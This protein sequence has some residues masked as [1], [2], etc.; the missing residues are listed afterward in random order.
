MEIDLCSIFDSLDMT[1]THTFS[2]NNPEGSTID[3]LAFINCE[4]A[5]L[6]LAGSSNVLFI[7][8]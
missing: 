3:S 8:R 2:N 1:R 4:D 7:F 5:S 6:L